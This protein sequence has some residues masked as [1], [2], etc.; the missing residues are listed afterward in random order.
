MCIYDLFAMEP[1]EICTCDLCAAGAM[2]RLF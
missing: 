2:H 1:A